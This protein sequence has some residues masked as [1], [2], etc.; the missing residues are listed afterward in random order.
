MT[1]SPQTICQ[2]FSPSKSS[3]SNTKAIKTPNTASILYH[4]LAVNSTIVDISDG[5]NDDDDSQDYCSGDDMM[6]NEGG[7]E[8]ESDDDILED[9]FDNV[10]EVDDSTVDV[11]DLMTDGIIDDEYDGELIKCLKILEQTMAEKVTL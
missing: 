8:N 10:S 4:N 3:H 5:I 1:T 7:N 6:W 9:F 11:L 2:L